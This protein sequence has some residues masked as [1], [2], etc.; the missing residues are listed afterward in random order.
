MMEPTVGRRVWYWP[1]DTEKSGPHNQPWDAGIAHVHSNDLI[2]ISLFDDLGWSQSGRQ[3]VTLA[4]DRDPV[5][6]ECGWMPYQLSAAK[7]P[8][9]RPA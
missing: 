6:G 3:N 8:A 9:T 1:L 5:P 2:N 7:T 4:Q